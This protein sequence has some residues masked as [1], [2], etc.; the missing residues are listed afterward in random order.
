MDNGRVS[1]YEIEIP[2]EAE[3]A[4]RDLSDAQRFV[5]RVVQ[6]LQQ[7]RWERMQ[8]DGFSLYENIMAEGISLV[9]APA[10]S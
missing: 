1:D 2:I 6:F 3:V 4:K 8:R 9:P 10:S 5:E 7:E